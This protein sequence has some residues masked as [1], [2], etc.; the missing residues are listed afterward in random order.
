MIGVVNEYNKIKEIK[1][2]NSLNTNQV[3][4]MNSMFQDYHEIE[5]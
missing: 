5:Y 1:G 4:N 3:A 2:I